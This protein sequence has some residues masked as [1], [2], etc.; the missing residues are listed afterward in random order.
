MLVLNVSRI[1]SIKI[2]R[3]TKIKRFFRFVES[4]LV[5]SYQKILMFTIHEKHE[6]KNSR[7]FVN[8]V[9]LADS[10]NIKL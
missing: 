4:F 3:L 7:N 9:L 2:F 1:L 6:A 10:K 5:Q 8:L